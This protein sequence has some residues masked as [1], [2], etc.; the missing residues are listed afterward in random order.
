MG[1]LPKKQLDLK[2]IIL[3]VVI[4]FLLILN[5]IL[6]LK[7]VIEPKNQQQNNE[8]NIVVLNEDDGKSKQDVKVLP[9][10]DEETVKYL[11]TLNER[12]RMEYYCGQFFKHIRY[13]E[14]EKAYKMLYSEFK[15]NYFKTEEEF[16]K[17]VKEHYPEML[18]LEYDDIQRFANM[19][20]IRLK[21]HNLGEEGDGETEHIQRIVVQE[22]YY[23]NYKISFQVE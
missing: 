6:V 15:E 22:Y 20:I 23:N 4:V 13:K 17:Y 3:I 11:A 21:L 10:T 12:G 2:D 1:K 16:E 14:Y 7:K 8:T 9:R 19:Y 5:L 18:G